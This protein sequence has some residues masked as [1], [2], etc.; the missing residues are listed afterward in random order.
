MAGNVNWYES[1]VVFAIEGATD[2]LLTQL[3][4]QCEGLAKVNIQANGQIDTGFMLNSTYGMGP[5]GDHRDVA[6]AEAQA[7]APRS[8]APRPSLE[9]GKAGVH[10]AAEYA[11]YQEVANSFLY[12]ALEQLQE[13]ASG[14]IQEVGRKRL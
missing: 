1:D 8:L 5:G 6:E 10:V 11:I 13:V 9:P 2:E 4:F 3:A 7:S 12:R 14:T